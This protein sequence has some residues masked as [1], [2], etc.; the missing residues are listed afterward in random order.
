LRKVNTSLEEH[1]GFWVLKPGEI[2]ANYFSF[3]S[4]DDHRMAM[5]F[6][7]LAT[8]A[9]IAIDTPEVVDKSYPGYWSDYEKAGFSVKR[10]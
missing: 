1:D 4:Y 8:L 7:P 5:S 6:A 9:S 10:I 3:H 2:N